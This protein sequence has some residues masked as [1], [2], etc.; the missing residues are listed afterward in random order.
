V[1]RGKAGGRSWNGNAAETEPRFFFIRRKRMPVR[2]GCFRVFA[3]QKCTDG[4]DAEGGFRKPCAFFIPQI[5]LKTCFE[6]EL[7]FYLFLK[8][9][10]DWICTEKAR[11]GTVIELKGTFRGSFF[12]CL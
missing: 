8:K 5:L 7:T 4:R 11:C 10:T 6:D 3:F 9:R 1:R 12:F 2:G